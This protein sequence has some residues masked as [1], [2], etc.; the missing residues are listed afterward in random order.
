[1]IKKILVAN[2]GEIAIR[3]M[4]AAREMGIETLGIYHEVD[5]KSYHLNFAD[6]AIQL[7]GVTPKSAYL[8]I[9]QIIQIAKRYNCDAIHP[10]Y[11]FLSENADFSEE[12]ER[13]GIIFIGPR[14]HSIK[15]MGSKT[16][17]R[18]IMFEAGVPIV[19]GT[20]E[21]IT[22]LNHGKRIADEIGYPVLLKAAAGGGGKGMRIV[23]N[24]SE[25]VEN[26]ESAQR[27]A[28]NSFRDDSIYIEKLIENAKHIEIQLI[29]DTHYNFVH[30]GE[31]DCS[32]QR[33]HQ[34]LIEECPSTVLDDELRQKMGQ[35]ALNAARAVE[36]INAGTVEFLFDNDKNFYFLEMNTR[37]QVEHPVTEM[38]TGIDLVREQISVAMGNPLSFKQSDIKW[39]SHAI[40]C[41]IN[42][43]DPY[44]D[45]M[46][47]IGKI[48]YYREPQGNGVRL[49]S[50]VTLGSE[51]SMYFDP[52]IAKLITYAKTRDLA[53]D[54]MQRALDE[55]LIGGLKTNTPF[56]K[57]ILKNK[58]F[59]SGEYNTN[60]L[61]TSFNNE[62]LPVLSDDEK[63]ILAAFA[64]YLKEN[65]KPQCEL[66]NNENGKNGSNWKLNNFYFRRLI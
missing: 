43:E 7:F 49:D 33:R 38:V 15:A 3:V 62:N 51:I 24:P 14:A 13:N 26:F 48:I 36:Y 4:R 53:I 16:Q 47:D 10:G 12:C 65:F 40:E 19:P 55:L 35:V 52:M 30:L 57:S 25:F 28:L 46:P 59:V 8:D 42:A 18:K 2:R 23:R 9:E 39:E 54:K 5:K 21:P 6:T 32:V 27:E 56:H 66:T 29:A 1:M 50:G 58:K 63:E 60:L 37:L 20:L 64:V 34:K 45:F 17:A 61:N 41:R 11:G 31:R 44:N 22:D